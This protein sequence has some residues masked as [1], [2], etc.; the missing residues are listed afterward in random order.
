MDWIEVGFAVPFIIKIIP[1]RHAGHPLI[2]VHI[3][4]ALINF[5]ELTMT[6]TYRKKN[7]RYRYIFFIKNKNARTN[8]GVHAGISD[9][10][11]PCIIAHR[12]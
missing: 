12:E 7:P 1:T 10:F 5:Y 11:I 9:P 3:K 2:K 8:H 6:R 4:S